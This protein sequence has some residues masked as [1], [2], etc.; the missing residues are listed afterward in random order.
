MLIY[1]N[2][3]LYP[4]EACVDTQRTESQW[5][6]ISTSTQNQVLIGNCYRPELAGIDY[7]NNL[8]K[9]M[10]SINDSLVIIT[11]NFNF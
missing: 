10:D 5:V 4:Y 6:Y 1:V 11:G 7:V 3:K 9:M 2:V 8:C